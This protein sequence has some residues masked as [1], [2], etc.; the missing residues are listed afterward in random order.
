MKTE[1]KVE[2]GASAPAK[3]EEF[4]DWD[5][6]RDF[7]PLLE[8][9]RPFTMVP[10][11]SLADLARVTRATLTYGIPGAFVECG[12]WRGGSSFLMAEL[13]KQAGAT[14]RKVW[15]FDS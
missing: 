9:V 11:E 6:A 12:V 4:L 13:L 3:S 2:M 5:D 8:R 1:M 10:T 7:A 15:L 14:D